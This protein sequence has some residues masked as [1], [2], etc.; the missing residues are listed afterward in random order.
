MTMKRKDLPAATRHRIL[1]EAGYKCGNP[2]CRHI[3]TLDIHHIVYVSDGGGDDPT[4][5]LALCPY[6][7][8]MHHAKQIPAEAIRLWK[9]MLLALNHAF[10]RVGMDL[11]LF[12]RETDGKDLW[13]SPDGLLH[14]ARLVAAGLVEFESKTEY[15]MTQ[16]S[17]AKWGSIDVF[18]NP[19]AH[20]PQVHVKPRL[21]AAG[22][23]LVD[24]WVAGDV[25]KF[26]E[27]VAGKKV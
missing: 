22:R 12:L 5:L 2:A 23:L 1:M 27:Y 18:C 10:D 14:F 8:S 19:I 26:T 25:E 3:I 17:S 20:S 11:L 9:G 13:Y 4:N 15:A 6:C 16:A 7:H 21:S 24:A